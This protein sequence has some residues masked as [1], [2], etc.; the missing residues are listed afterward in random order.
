MEYWNTINRKRIEGSH[1]LRLIYEMGKFLL[2]EM[3]L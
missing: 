3:M 1:L 2:I